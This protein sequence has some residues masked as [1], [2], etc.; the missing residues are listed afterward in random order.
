MNE[1]VVVLFVGCVVCG[2]WGIEVEVYDIIGDL[3]CQEVLIVMCCLFIFVV[4]VVV[5]VVVCVFM[6]MVIWQCGV[7][8]LQCN[9]VVCVDCII[10]VFKS[11]FDC[12]ELLFYLFGSYLYVQDLFVEFKCGDYIVCVNCYF[13]DF[14]EYVYVIVIYVIG[15]DGLCVV[16]SN[17][18]VFDSF[19][20]IEYCFCLYFFDVM[21]GQVGCFFGIGMILCDFG[22]YIL[23]FVWYDGKIVGVV[24]V[25][26]NFEW[27]QGVDVFELFVVVDDYGVVFL[28]LVFVWKYYM[29]CLFM[30][31]VVVLIYE[32][33]QY[34]Q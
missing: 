6:W 31:L 18:C 8:E 33:C 26:F 21:N 11:M 7:V 17:W 19:V 20:G 16:V 28:L 15:V 14:N 13:E 29:L 2:V 34:V 3:Y 22:Y 25:K 9:V 4:F 24:V 27:F 30:G 1:Q 12:Y 10:N 5:F 32:M 23:Q